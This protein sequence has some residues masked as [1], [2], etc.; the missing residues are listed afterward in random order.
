[1]FEN[2]VKSQAGLQF[3][4]QVKWRSIPKIGKENELPIPI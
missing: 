3:E 2:I 4:N 1:M